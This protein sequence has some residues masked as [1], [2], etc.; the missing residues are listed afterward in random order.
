MHCTYRTII[1]P[2]LIHNI[3]I[4]MLQIICFRVVKLPPQLNQ[5]PSYHFI[6]PE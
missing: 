4:A 3:L 2:K 6:E 5:Q 1:K